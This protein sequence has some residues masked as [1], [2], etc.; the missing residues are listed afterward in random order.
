MITK[1]YCPRCDKAVAHYDGNTKNTIK[2]KCK[3]CNKLV[4][5]SPKL[6]YAILTELPPR[7]TSSGMRFY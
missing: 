1:I 2:V 3:N 6:G 7:V 4:V 5:Y